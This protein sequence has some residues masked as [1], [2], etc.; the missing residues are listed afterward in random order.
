MCSF[1]IFMHNSLQFSAT[2]APDRPVT[3]AYP[4]V[5]RVELKD[6]LLTI[7]DATGPD[8]P[9][10]TIYARRTMALDGATVF[11]I[12]PEPPPGIR[13]VKFFGAIGTVVLFDGDENYRRLKTT[14]IDKLSGD[15]RAWTFDAVEIA[16]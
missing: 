4:E 2:D 10:N 3:E 14:G 11:T 8:S 6:N 15:W 13:D 7:A 16:A 9:G 1:S 12:L 5:L